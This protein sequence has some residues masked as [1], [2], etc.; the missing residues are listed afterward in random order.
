M[1]ICALQEK[2]GSFLEE[3]QVFSSLLL[4]LDKFGYGQSNP[5]YLLRIYYRSSSGTASKTPILS[6]VLR[7]KPKI[8]A[9]SSAH[10]LHREYRVLSALAE[11]NGRQQ[12]QHACEPYWWLYSQTIPVP[13]VY[14]YCS[15]PSVLGA[16][17]YIMQYMSGRLWTHPTLEQRQ[18]E[19]SN[20]EKLL[21][22]LEKSII[23]QHAL[24]VLANIHSA[25]RA[26]EQTNESLSDFGKHGGK[27]FVQR[28]L[29]RLVQVYQAQELK[30]R[31][32][33][34]SHE[35]PLFTNEEMEELNGQ[36]HQLAKQ[37]SK[38]ARYCPDGG[39]VTT[40]IHGDYKMDNFIIH[41]TEPRIIAVLDW[42]LSTLGDP[43]CDLANLSMMYHVP[44]FI[45][46]ESEKT[47]KKS[48]SQDSSV[49]AF[50]GFQGLLQSGKSTDG[51][52]TQ[53][54]ASRMMEGIPTQEQLIGYYG[55]QVA[56]HSNDDG[57]SSTSR[58]TSNTNSL[59]EMSPFSKVSS[60]PF[61]WSNQ[62][63]S[64]KRK[65]LPGPASPLI[66]TLL[67]WHG[68]YLA[69][70]FFKNAVIVHGVAQRAQL[71]VA[72]SAGARQVGRLL[73][74][75]IRTSLEILQDHPPPSDNGAITLPSS[76]L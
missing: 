57:M 23:Y 30:R 33:V 14:A 70:L 52:P 15:D 8:T 48:R 58:L 62:T 47:T 63:T 34:P 7:K 49:I 42:E 18:Q 16:E 4:D 5:T 20:G 24:V 9:H 64:P 13:A 68:F 6:L 12:P 29:K 72:S 1:I 38:A 41:P 76:R 69:F 43:A 67:D 73:P 36:L 51:Y 40:L 31:E 11:Y 74:T 19:K 53:V 71:G 28:Q 39:N 37:L 3:W 59:K 22:P 60:F 45:P 10:A 44:Y 35:Q 61:E 26:D 56:L 66:K 25:M 27:Q 65:H 75:I 46:T 55:E 21:G 54:E 32:S 17:F 2:E 50:A